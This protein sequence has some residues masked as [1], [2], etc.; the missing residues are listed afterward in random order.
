VRA[1][2]AKI[3][4][5]VLNCLPPHEAKVVFNDNASMALGAELK[6]RQVK[7]AP[8]SVKYPTELGS[9]YTLLLTDPDA[10]TAEDRS[11]GEIIHWLVVNIPGT[12]ISL[13]ETYYEYVGAG[14]PE[15]TGLHRYVLTV[16]K[17][18]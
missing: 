8:T 5:D 16:F 14:T 17:Q 9:L 12:D 7:D 2:E 3:V 11:L 15:G 18:H 13:G 1:C 10:P 6:P 4:P